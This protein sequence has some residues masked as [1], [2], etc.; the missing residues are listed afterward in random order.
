MFGPLKKPEM[1]ADEDRATLRVRE[2]RE[3]DAAALLRLK[4]Q[5]F[6]ETDNLLQTLQD[7]DFDAEEER[8][9]VRRYRYLDN[10]ALLVAAEGRTLHGFLSLQGGA[11]QRNRHV[12]QLGIAVRRAVW[13]RGIGRA[14]MEGGL[15]WARAT[16]GVGRVSLLVYADNERA[17]RLYEDCGFVREGVLR[18]EVYLE[19]TGT[20][21]D[22]VAMGLLLEP[23]FDGRGG[24]PR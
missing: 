1:L 3:G 12:V 10:S 7:Y 4:Q 6:A 18:G 11:L 13:G 20:Y 15:A 24:V 2:A 21:M 16:P 23:P 9:L 17:I 19:R 8:Y 5:V 22:L 14:L